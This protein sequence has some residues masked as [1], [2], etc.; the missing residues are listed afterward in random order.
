MGT[1]QKHVSLAGIFLIWHG[2]KSIWLFEGI[3]LCELADLGKF[4]KNQVC[5]QARKRWRAA[6]PR[7]DIH[8]S[9]SKADTTAAD[10][11]AAL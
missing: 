6:R 3:R 11:V 7:D 2:K 8:L 10:I 9:L 5:W 4:S 1:S